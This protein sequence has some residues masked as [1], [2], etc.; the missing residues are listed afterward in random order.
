MKI[1]LAARVAR[2]VPVDEEVGEKSLLADQADFVFHPIQHRVVVVGIAVGQT[3]CTQRPHQRLVLVFTFRVRVGIVVQASL[4]RL[5]KGHGASG[6]EVF[7]PRHEVGHLG[8]RVPQFVGRAKT[9]RGSPHSASSRR[10]R[11]VLWSMARNSRCVFQSRLQVNV[12]VDNAT[13]LGPSAGSRSARARRTAG[14]SH[15]C[16]P[17]HSSAPRGSRSKGSEEGSEGSRGVACVAVVR[18]APNGP[19]I[20][21]GHAGGADVLGQPRRKGRPGEVQFGAPPAQGFVPRGVPGQGHKPPRVAVPHVDAQHGR[22]PK[23]FRP[24]H[25][26]PVRGRRSHVRQGHARHPGSLG[27]RQHVVDGQDAVAQAESAVGVQVHGVGKGRGTT[28]ENGQSNN[29]P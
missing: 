21:G 14:T 9:V 5:G 15:A 17:T 27:P 26:V 8:V 12:A 23:P 6:Q 16:T 7:S 20:D 13:S 24:P 18:V 1:P 4:G 29:E 19:G 2:D 10:L 3:L 11:S 28:G 25:K 22:H